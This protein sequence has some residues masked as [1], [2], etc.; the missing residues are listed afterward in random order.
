MKP[1]KPTFKRQHSSKIKR[2]E[3]KGWRHPR[4]IDSAQ[5]RHEKSRGAHPRIGYGSPAAEKGMHP[6]GLREVLIVKMSDLAKV[7]EGMVARLSAT[8]GK[9]KRAEIVEKAAEK[10]I[11]VLN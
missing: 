5:Q 9:K 2:V 7:G 4:G 3:G 8:L 1:K 10:K 11:K 6:S